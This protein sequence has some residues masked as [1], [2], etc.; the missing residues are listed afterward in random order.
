[1]GTALRSLY[2][3]GGIRRFYRGISAALIVSIFSRLLM[4]KF[5]NQSRQ[6]PSH[7]RLV[8]ISI[9][10]SEIFSPSRIKLTNKTR[11]WTLNRSI[12]RRNWRIL[13]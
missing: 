7:H 13:N 1:M 2:A 4:V 12:D 10:F 3:D 9:N 8:V 5:F 11:I 6:E